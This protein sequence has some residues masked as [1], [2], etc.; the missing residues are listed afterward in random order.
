MLSQFICCDHV[1]LLGTLDFDFPEGIHAV[2]RLDADSE[3]LLLLTTNKK[4]TKLLFKSK[5][6]HRRT[7]L[8]NVKNNVSQQTLDQLRNGV[9]I[10]T[11]LTENYLAVPDSA[12]IIEHLD[13]YPF[14][15][16]LE[17]YP[18]PNTWLRICLTEGKFRQ[19]RKMVVAINHPCRRL[20][21]VSIEDMML[22]DLK[23]GGVH[24]FSE[25]DFFDKL[26]LKT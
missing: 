19:V 17:P 4:I 15:S 26:K 12:D 7:Y 23:A 11:G 21:R 2:G 25:A 9:E 18:Y 1:N 10:R 14:L 6:P 13:E 16:G 5:I 20:I 3:G 8:V 24:E 22:G